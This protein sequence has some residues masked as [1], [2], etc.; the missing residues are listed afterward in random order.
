[1]ELSLLGGSEESGIAR[2]WARRKVKALI[3]SMRGGA[4]RARVAEEVTTLGLRHHLVTKWTSLVA[5][6]VTPTAP[7]GV[8]P[9]T[10]WIP[11]LLPKGWTLRGLFGGAPRAVGEAERAM[12]PPLP[13]RSAAKRTTS[14]PDAFASAGRLAVALAGREFPL[15]CEKFMP[16]FSIRSPPDKTWLRPPPPPGRCHSSVCCRAPGS[17]SLNRAIKR[18]CRSVK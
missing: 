17:N 4:D 11:T 6:D 16:P 10:R 8:E 1:M 13:L 2:L 18:F 12:S 7:V 9:D 3:D 14:Q 5:V 15:T